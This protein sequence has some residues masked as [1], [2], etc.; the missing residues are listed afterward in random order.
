M[1]MR[2]RPRLARTAAL[3]AAAAVATAT[4]LAGT[5][6][7][8]GESAA[9]VAARAWHSVFPDHPKTAAGER[10][11]VVLSSPSVAERVAAAAEPPS[12]AQE[13]EWA[14]DVVAMQTSLLA[15]L[16]E[17]GIDVEPVRTYTHVLDGFSA[18]LDGRA[19]AEFERNPLVVGVYPARAVFPAE[20]REPGGFGESPGVELAGFDGAGVRIALLD[21][22]VDRSHPELR[23]RIGRGH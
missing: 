14:D 12:A 23:G 6:Q 4:V 3:G 19:V 9:R 10:M 20:T 22:G 11:I 18:V 17:R 7:G 15:A 13:N 16:R 1:R 21:T 8:A 2:R 5:V